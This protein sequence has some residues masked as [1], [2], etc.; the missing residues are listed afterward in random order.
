MQNKKHL[1]RIVIF[2][3]VVVLAIFAIHYLVFRDIK[4]KNEFISSLRH[5][6]SLNTDEKTYL[7]DTQSTIDNLSSDLSRINS[8]IITKDGDVAFIEEL[9]SVAKQNNLEIDIDSLSLDD[10]ALK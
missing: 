7:I 1:Q 2:L 10:N 8:Y 4:A 6:L 3:C 5:D 9:E